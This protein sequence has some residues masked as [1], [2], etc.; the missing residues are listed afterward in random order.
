M[1]LRHRLD[2][3]RVQATPPVVWDQPLLRQVLQSPGTNTRREP[4]P[5]HAVGRCN[6]LTGGG[7]LPCH[8]R[9]LCLRYGAVRHCRALGWREEAE[10]PRGE[11]EDLRLGSLPPSL[12]YQQTKSRGESLTA[13]P[14]INDPHGKALH[15]TGAT[16]GGDCARKSRSH[17]RTF[18][19]THDITASAREHMN[20]NP[21]ISEEN[22]SG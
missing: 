22:Q 14:W 18:H 17:A 9:P 3:P 8:I 21:V 10:E 15:R 1:C 12:L 13:N 16:H 11:K 4:F 5:R 2:L 7:G 20:S 19:L 6:A